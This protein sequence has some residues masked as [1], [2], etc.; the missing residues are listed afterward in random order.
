MR[1]LALYRD[2]ERVVCAF[3]LYIESKLGDADELRRLMLEGLGRIGG[4]YQTGEGPVE[5]EARADITDRFSFGALNVRIIDE[6]PVIRKWYSPKINVSRAYYGARR[7]GLLKL[8][9][10]I[11]RKPDL[12]INLAGR[13]IRDA[14]QRG[15]VCSVIQHELGHVL[16]F[17][18]KYR[19]RSFKKKNGSVEDGDIMYRVGPAQR[20]MEYHI[21]RLKSCADKGRIPFKNV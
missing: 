2:G 20:F 7:R 3:T 21:R 18:D 12:Y 10:F 16:G 17:K 19:M 8:Q 15:V 13:D 6:T 14:R 4:R 9:R 5:V 11:W 1:P